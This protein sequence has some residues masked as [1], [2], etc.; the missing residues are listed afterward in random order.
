METAQHVQH[1]VAVGDGLAE[2]GEAIGDVFE[3]SEVRE[4]GGGPLVD[5]AELCDEEDSLV[6]AVLQEQSGDGAPEL[7]SRGVT[8]VDEPKDLGADAVVQPGDDEGIV[9]EPVGSRRAWRIGDVV[10]DA[11]LGEGD[12]E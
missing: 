6:L 8:L 9:L 2:I 10:V 1:L 7:F 4:D 3:A 5:A 12:L 11:V